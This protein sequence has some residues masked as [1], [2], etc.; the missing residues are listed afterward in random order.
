MRECYTITDDRIDTWKITIYLEKGC[1]LLFE[2]RTESEKIMELKNEKKT[3]V[4]NGLDTKSMILVALF[5]ALTAIGAFL[6]N[7]PTVPFTLQNLFSTMS[8]L[9]LGSNLGALAVG[10][11]VLLFNRSA[12][13]YFRRRNRICIKADFRISFRIYYRGMGNG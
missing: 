8:G 13:V 3:F 7:F 10:I 6:K 11:Y 1:A 5:T 12:C 2:N 9:L 4:K